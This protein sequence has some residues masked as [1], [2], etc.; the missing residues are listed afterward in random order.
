[1]TWYEELY[2]H[3]DRKDM[4]AVG[5]SFADDVVMTMGNGEPVVGRVNV[6]ESLRQFQSM[7]AGLSHT[8]TAVAEQGDVTM[9]ETITR[10]DLRSGESVEIKGVTLLERK[11][12]LI[13]AQ[14]M[15]ADMAP[16]W[17]AQQASAAASTPAGGQ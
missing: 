13:T 8:F 9:L 2:A 7:L 12:E 16:L 1:M 15:Y 4:D 3:V 10:F 17:A 11:G 5:A 6:I 14:R